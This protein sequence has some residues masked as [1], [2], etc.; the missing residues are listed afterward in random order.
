MDPEGRLDAEKLGYL[1]VVLAIAGHD[2]DWPMA[3]SEH[4]E[5]VDSVDWLALRDGAS[6][7]REE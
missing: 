6:S 4:L 3:I 1:R 2:V 5:P 7:D